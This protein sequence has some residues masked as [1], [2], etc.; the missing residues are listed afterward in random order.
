MKNFKIIL[1]VISF[2]ALPAY[3]QQSATTI[4]ALLERVEQGRVNDNLENQKREAEFRQKRDQ[5]FVL[6][7]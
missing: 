5:P 6:R 4:D 3:S 7:V 1:A 2:I